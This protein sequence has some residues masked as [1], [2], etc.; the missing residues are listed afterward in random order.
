MDYC[1]QGDLLRYITSKNKELSSREILTLFRQLADAFIFMTGRGVIHRDLKPEN[2]L[3]SGDCLKIADFGCARN[4]KSDEISKLICMSLDKGTPCFAS[5][6]LLQSQA[7][8]FKCDVWSAGCI[9]YF[10]VYRKLPFFAKKVSQ[11]IQ[12]IKERTENKELELPYAPAA[13]YEL[14]YIIKRCLK[15]R[16]VERATWREF[17]LCRLFVDKLTSIRQY[18]E[19]VKSLSNIAN[20]LSKMFW[21]ERKAY[22]IKE[23][24]DEIFVYF[25]IKFQLSVLQLGQNIMERNAEYR[26][27]F[28]DLAWNKPDVDEAY[29]KHYRDVH[30]KETVD[31][32]EML[33]NCPKSEQANRVIKEK[34]NGQLLPF[35]DL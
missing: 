23:N 21:K 31:Y 7:Y 32:F 3:M 15:F 4:M 6:E 13:T 27:M 34:E 8:S 22:K 18:C 28:E 35:V 14:Q 5:P 12:L 17:S 19:Y 29:Y 11:I 30:L 10:M 16:E 1:E 25:I 24:K 20:W 33:K 2:I 9:I 26:Y